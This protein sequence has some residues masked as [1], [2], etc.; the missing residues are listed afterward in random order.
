MDNFVIDA[1]CWRYRIALFVFYPALPGTAVNNNKPRPAFFN[2]I[3][4][5]GAA[6][7]KVIYMLATDVGVQHLEPIVPA[8]GAPNGRVPTA[9]YVTA[10]DRT[11]MAEDS[12]CMTTDQALQTQEMRDRVRF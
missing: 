12:Y 5:P 7:Q 10:A 4:G 11:R 3:Q 6:Q 2:R 1:L 9:G 8:P